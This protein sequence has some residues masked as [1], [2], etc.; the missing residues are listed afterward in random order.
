V[1]YLLEP[2]TTPLKVRKRN[3]LVLITAEAEKVTVR[4]CW[5]I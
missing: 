3:A 4:K 1:L 5:E 2:E